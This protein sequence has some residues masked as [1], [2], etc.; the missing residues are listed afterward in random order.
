MY[1]RLSNTRNAWQPIG[2]VQGTCSLQ[3]DWGGSAGLVGTDRVR[4]ATCWP[5]PNAWLHLV[6]SPGA[7]RL[8]ERK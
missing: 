6:S 2:E 8:W 4:R 1:E 5:C 3:P 7:T